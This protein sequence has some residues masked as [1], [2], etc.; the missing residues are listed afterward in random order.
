MSQCLEFECALEKE[1]EWENREE[2]G[3]KITV[4]CKCTY[5]LHAHFHFDSMIFQ[6]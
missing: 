6:L 4:M 3:R 2:K 5:Q 1:S